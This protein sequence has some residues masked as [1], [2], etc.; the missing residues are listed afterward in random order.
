MH[1]FQWSFLDRSKD[2]KR[3]ASETF[4]LIIVGG[5]ITGAGIAREAALRN[6]KF[7]IIDKNDFAF[8][9]S[10]KSSKLAHGGFRYL[11]N[12]DFKL[13]RESTTERNW[14]RVSLPNLVRPLAFNMY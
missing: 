13:V 9:T 12:G 1:N 4:D 3:A 2:L 8:G 7:I 6:L 14:M 5:G 10:S 11:A